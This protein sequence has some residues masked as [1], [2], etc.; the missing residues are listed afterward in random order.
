MR[1]ALPALAEG[2][3]EECGRQAASP[4]QAQ[5]ALERWATLRTSKLQPRD[6][7]VRRGP[8]YVAPARTEQERGLWAH[9]VAMSSSPSCASTTKVH[10]A[11]APGASPLHMHWGSRAA[12]VQMP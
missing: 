10:A 4:L 11:R 1:A 8:V 12:P 2:G 6:Y 3:A 7:S 5:C 9:R